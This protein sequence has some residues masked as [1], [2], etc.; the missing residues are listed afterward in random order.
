MTNLSKT[1]IPILTQHYTLQPLTLLKKIV[2]PIDQTTKLLF[3]TNDQEKIESVLMFFNYGNSACVST[4]IGCNMG[5]KFC[6]SGLL[7]KV[8]NLNASEIV[9]QIM[10]INQYLHA[11]KQPALSN[12]VFMGIGEPF[13]NYEQVSQALRIINCPHGL[14]IGARK[15]TVSTCGVVDKI[16]PF[17]RDFPQ[18]NLAISLHAPN[19][20][21]RNEIMPI[22]HRYPLVK[23]MET[24]QAYQQLVNRK[25][26]F[27]YLLLKDVNDH[28]QHAEELA[29]LVKPLH[30]LVNLIKYNNVKERCFTRSENSSRF[31]KILIRH[32]INTT[33]RLERGINI[34]AACGQLRAEHDKK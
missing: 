6:A 16:L 5:C 8:R 28:D 34:N 21:I 10:Y 20:Q 27:E 24:L 1:I 26:T 12:I 32:K 18:M 30:C 11:Q 14:G 23:L 15:I 3:A 25:I 33:T 29:Q 2:D 4:Q 9:Q 19:D 17:A 22:N 7:K 13:D 31:A